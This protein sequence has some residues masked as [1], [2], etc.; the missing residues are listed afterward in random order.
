M[1]L[2]TGSRRFPGAAVL[3]VS[4]AWHTGIGAVKLFTSEG[5]ENVAQLVMSRRPETLLVSRDDEPHSDALVVGS[6]TAPGDWDSAWGTWLQT[7]LEAQT[8]TVV[9]AGAMLPVVQ[10]SAPLTHAI[11]TPHEGE[12]RSL[13][14]LLELGDPPTSRTERVS[15]LAQ[16]LNTT[17]VL[18]GNSTVVAAGSGE[19]TVLPPA[20]P[21]LAT[22]GTGDVLSGVIGSILA[23]HR[24]PPTEH[25]RHIA[26]TACSLHDTAARLAAGHVRGVDA[27]A[28]QPVTAGEVAEHLSRA[29]YSL[30]SE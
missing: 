4:A 27:N 7:Q 5:E 14:K 25:Y 16:R 30:A 23:S 9:D 19:T 28:G 29:F 15:A 1:L 11:L 2:R 13:W 22:A 20:T 17:V 10:L 24:Q 21:W 3:S 12:F 6:G 26:V 8:P 18:K